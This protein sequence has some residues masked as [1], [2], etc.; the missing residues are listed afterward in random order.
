[1]RHLRFAL[2]LFLFAGSSLVIS[3]Q[4]AVPTAIAPPVEGGGGPI[5]IED[6]GDDVPAQFRAEGGLRASASAEAGTSQPHP[7][8]VFP[9]AGT[10]WKDIYINNFVDLSPQPG[11]VLTFDCSAHSYDGHLGHDSDLRSFKVQDIGV[12]IFAALPGLV[13]DAHDGEFDKSTDLTPKPANYVILD[14]GNTHR[15]LYWHMKKDSVAVQIGDVVPAGAQ[16][17][18][19]GSSGYST[20][21]HLHFESQFEGSHYEPSAGPCRP[22][23]SNWTSQPPFPGNFYVEDFAFSPNSFGEERAGPPYD[24][25]VRVGTF[26]IGNRL[27]YSKIE[28]ANV[29][30]NSMYLLKYVRPDATVALEWADTFGNDVP[31]RRAWWHWAFWVDLNVTG[32]WRKQIYVNDEL[33][34][35][36]PFT[37]VASP[38]QVVNRPPNPIEAAFEDSGGVLSVRVTTSAVTEDPDY[39]IVSYRYQWRADGMIVREVVSAA[40]AD[41]LPTPSVDAGA[42]VIV[43]VTPFDGQLYGPEAIAAPVVVDPTLMVLNPN[44]GET[45]TA[46]MPYRVEWVAFADPVIYEILLSTDGGFSF[47][48]VSCVF[49]LADP[50]SCMWQP[51]ATPTAEARLRIVGRNGTEVWTDESDADFVIVEPPANLVVSHTY[52]PQPAAVGQNLT[53]TARVTNQG[54]GVATNIIL[55]H[56]RP[57][58][59][60]LQSTGATQ[61]TCATAS[62][63]TCSLGTL[64]AG[65]SATVTVT[66]RPAQAGTFSSAAS[67]VAHQSDPNTTDNTATAS[68]SVV[69]P[70]PSA[71]ISLTSPNTV[72]NW[73]VGSVQ[74]IRWTHT[75]GAGSAVRIE[76]SRD[77]GATYR[78]TIAAPAMNGAA[79]TGVYNWRV[80]GPN[81]A[82]ARIRVSTTDGSVVGASNANFTIGPVFIK[83]AAPAAG[84]SWGYG[85]QQTQAWATN[86]GPLDKVNVTLSTNGGGTFTTTLASGAV[87]SKNGTNVLTPILA[88]PASLARVR[89]TWANPPAG[90]SAAGSNPGNFRI[91]PPLIAVTSP[92]LASDAWTKGTTRT[93][94]WTSNLGPLENVKVEL[95]L[96]GGATYTIAAVASTPSDGS[97]PVSVTGPWATT[98]ARVRIAWIRKPAINDI[99]NESFPIR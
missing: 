66:V 70:A 65:G 89:I 95:S 62:P 80:T 1:M 29:P 52:S 31:W 43:S 30:D 64:P 47:M 86:L 82:K 63:G 67:A 54:P 3:G 9:H 28:M 2:A 79:T 40:T 56:A 76:I 41:M 99:S 39:A 61:G 94:T 18:L 83:V 51:P 98:A 45:V 22:G 53:L 92:N 57:A 46:G 42:N 55:T 60:S 68:V 97:Q 26:S 23:P 32:T 20:G 24:E 6:A 44:G 36:A 10:L 35:D 33:V 87:A 25:A 11:E 74:P 8:T 69:A 81:T 72:V 96:N 21:P 37:V 34:V 59:W 85:T 71:S 84:A 75:L 38:S 91:A 15:S 12:P 7:Y 48:P 13:V 4:T 88:S 50:Y 49:E 14:H 73:G 93:V 19:V 17:G 27:V 77:G 78:E 58:S 90:L 5:V 16:L